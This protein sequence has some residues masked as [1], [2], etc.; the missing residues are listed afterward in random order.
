MVI[1]ATQTQDLAGSPVLS[2]CVRIFTRF[3]SSAALGARRRLSQIVPLLRSMCVDGSDQLVLADP[4]SSD[5]YPSVSLRGPS[6][7]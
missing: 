4:C 5:Q 7:S 6:F 3:A 1:P 2:A